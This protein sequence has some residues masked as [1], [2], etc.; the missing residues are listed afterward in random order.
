MATR[1]YALLVGINDYPSDVGKLAGCLNDIG[2]AHNSLGQRSQAD[3]ALAMGLANRV[4]PKG[5]ARPAAEEFGCRECDE[6]AGDAAGEGEQ[7][8]FDE[9]LA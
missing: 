1:V 8:A 9:Q 6:Q 5:Q 7:R 4:V 3:E 2:L